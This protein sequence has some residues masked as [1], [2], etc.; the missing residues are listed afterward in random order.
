MRSPIILAVVL[1]LAGCSSAPPTKFYGLTP[2]SVTKAGHAAADDQLV[3]GV[4]P[5]ELPKALDRPQLPDRICERFPRHWLLHGK[6]G[7]WH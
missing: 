4:G 5:V 7:P 6:P 1:L 2:V 3:I